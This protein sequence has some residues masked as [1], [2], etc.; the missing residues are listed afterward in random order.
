MQD[1]P[2]YQETLED[3]PRVVYVIPGDPVPLARARCGNG[4]FYDSQKNI[5]V[6]A[7]IYLQQQHQDGI[8]FSGPVTLTANFYLYLPR[9]RSKKDT[10]HENSPHFYRPDLSN[11]IKFVEDLITD[12]EIWKDDCI[13]SEIYAKK[14]YSSEPR[15]ELI[16]ERYHEQNQ[17]K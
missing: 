11:L 9:R 10:R 3:V 13:I 15:T 16:I 5:K 4:R 17:P 6:C 2:K 7:G 12:V 14:I 8:I 1:E